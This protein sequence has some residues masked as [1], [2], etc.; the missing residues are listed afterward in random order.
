MKY[1]IAD[2]GKPVGP[3]EPQELLSHG[4][5]INS[6]VWCET[7]SS[8]KSASEVPE[9]VTLL[10]ATPHTQETQQQPY[11]Q[12]PY[13]QQPYQQQPYQQPYQQAFGS[14]QQY[15]APMVSDYK[16]INW[17]LLIASVVC[18]CCANPIAVISGVIGVIYSGKTADANLVGAPEAVNYSKTAQWCAIITAALLVLGVVASMF[19]MRNLDTTQWEEILREMQTAGIDID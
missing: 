17:L 5:T 3:F 13:Q 15:R 16:V 14:Q 18:C 8:W 9:L 11:Q 2:R 4:L 7:M 1:Y 6:L 12:Q 19:Y 10:G